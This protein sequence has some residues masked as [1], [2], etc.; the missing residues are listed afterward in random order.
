MLHIRKVYIRII[1]FTFSTYIIINFIIYHNDD[2]ASYC[3]TL[4]TYVII[5][6]RSYASLFNGSLKASCFENTLKH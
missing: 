4:L 3:I 1:N 2:I 5:Y 6:M